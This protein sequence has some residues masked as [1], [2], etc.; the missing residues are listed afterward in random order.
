MSVSILMEQ[1]LILFLEI[2]VG[3]LGAKTGVLSDQ[4]SKTLSDLVMRITLPCTL[5]SSANIQAASGSTV[6]QMLL[7]A[8]L[9]LGLYCVSCAVCFGIAK[10]L[11]LDRKKRAI[12]VALAVMPNSA[13]VGIPL[14]TAVLGEASGMVYSASGI[15][16]YNLFFFVYVV[17]LF[18]PGKGFEIKS[19]ITPANIATLVMVGM[20]LSGLRLPSMLQ[21]FVGAVGNCTT[22]LALIIV[23]I[24]LA[25][26]DW[27]QLLR[28]RFL[29]L[30]TLLRC[31]VFPLAFLGVLRL[32]GLDNTLSMGVFILASCPA[33][34]LGAVL[35]KQHNVEPELASQAVAQSTLF[36]LISVPA[37]LMLAS[38]LFLGG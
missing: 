32:L 11:H 25:G 9:L 37:L 15:L 18:Q 26:S 10:L 20:L 2:G 14:C 8:V 19:L 16:A 5:I 34:S 12:L 24:M 23:G 35:A 22:P 3:V 33:G 21:S 38:R 30:I 4:S 1:V 29:Y 27:R 13:F 17:Q 7:G 28:G 36:I 31:I 6:S